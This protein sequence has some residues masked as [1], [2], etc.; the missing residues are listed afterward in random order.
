ML[1]QTFVGVRRRLGP[2]TKP[3][4]CRPSN[5]TVS[6]PSFVVVECVPGKDG[7]PAGIPFLGG[8]WGGYAHVAVHERNVYM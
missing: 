1:L 6:Y 3:W 7:P 4:P 8:F 5:W 2:G